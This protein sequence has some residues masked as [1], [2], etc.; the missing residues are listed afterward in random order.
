MREGLAKV[1]PGRLQS[2]QV[3]LIT[4][5]DDW[6]LIP[7]KVP[8]WDRRKTRL[9]EAHPECTAEVSLVLH[10]TPSVERRG[11]THTRAVRIKGPVKGRQ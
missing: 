9:S 10:Y 1:S 8:K 2:G 3:R 7:D 5:G 6:E 11:N 4:Y